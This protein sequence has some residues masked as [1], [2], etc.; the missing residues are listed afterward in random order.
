MKEIFQASFTLVNIIP[1]VLLLFV[2]GYWII[3]F[4]G[5]LDMDSL[6]IDVDVDADIDLDTDL[7]VDVDT[8]IDADLDADS[9][10]ESFSDS[11]SWFN[12]VLVFFNLHHLPL[13]VFLSFLA[14]PMWAISVLGNHYLGNESFVFALVLLVPNLIVS[15]MAAKV[16]TIPVARVFARINENDE[17]T[18]PIGKICTIQLPVR[19]G[20]MGQGVIHDLNGNVVRINIVGS[21]QTEIPKNGTALVIKYLDD[22]KSYLVEPYDE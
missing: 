4:A 10:T 15:L 6:D 1:T 22:K 5:L 14:L 16:V 21:S 9:D 18:N 12:Q 3:V 20:K 13:M 8:D 2:A 7:D 17:S 11:V 19:P